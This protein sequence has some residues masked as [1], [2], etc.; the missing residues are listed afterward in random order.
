MRKLTI[1]L[2]AMF[3][4]L[5]YAGQSGLHFAGLGGTYSKSCSTPTVAATELFTTVGVECVT[6][7]ALAGDVY[8]STYAATS[9]TGLWKIVSGAIPQTINSGAYKY[10]LSSGTVSNSLDFHI[11]R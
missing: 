8:I 9:T 10:G 2:I 6:Y 11:E 5:A 3:P 4:M 7:Q 1:L